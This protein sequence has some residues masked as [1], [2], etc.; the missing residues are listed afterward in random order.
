MYNYLTIH[1]A[2]SAVHYNHSERSL[3]GHTLLSTQPVEWGKRLGNND[4]EDKLL[5]SINFW[6]L[7]ALTFITV[8]S[9]PVKLYK[10][11]EILL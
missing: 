2:Y 1:Y 7:I 8:L 9:F 10:T 5:D 6:T 4:L 11:E 3:V